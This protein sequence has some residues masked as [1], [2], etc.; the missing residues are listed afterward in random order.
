MGWAASVS[1]ARKCRECGY[2]GNMTARDL[3]AH[4][5][6]SHPAAVRTAP[7]PKLN[8]EDVFDTLSSLGAEMA[9]RRYRGSLWKRRSRPASLRG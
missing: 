9:M 2:R 8:V 7:L 4:A 6:A 3:S 1:K 5:A